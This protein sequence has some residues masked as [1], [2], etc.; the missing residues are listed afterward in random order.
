METYRGF[1][2]RAR[3]KRNRI[4]LIEAGLAVL[5]VAL[6]FGILYTMVKMIHGEPV[7]E[8]PVASTIVQEEQQEQ[9]PVQTQPVEAEEWDTN[10]PSERTI[11]TDLQLT[12]DARMLALPAN[13]KLSTEY[14][15][16]AL[17]I[18]DSLT[19]GFGLYQP[20][21]DVAIV[22]AYKSISP[23]FILDGGTAKNYNGVEEVTKDAIAAE[24]PDNIY[25]LLGTNAVLA[26]EDDAFLHYYGELMDW[27]RETF[28]NVPIYVQSITPV[29]A[30]EEIAKPRLA[31]DH[32]RQLNDQIAKMAV[33]RGFYFVNVQ[34]ALVDDNGYLRADYVGTYDGIHMVPAGYAAW[35][36]YLLRH[37]AYSK[38]NSQFVEEGPYNG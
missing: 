24:K 2:A 23:K 28:P 33:E 5:I 30:E 6:L 7:I 25:L 1:K 31:N 10:V 32:L 13:G 26:Q 18:G 27:L 3:R 38:Y 19:Q 12:A 9:T 17:F 16:T 34:E 8:W 36:D 14:F 35:A 11:N 22:H 20:T 15:R 37:T 29:T 4:L 21:S